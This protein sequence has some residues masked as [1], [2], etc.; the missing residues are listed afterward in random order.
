MTRKEQILLGYYRGFA[1]VQDLKA[2]LNDLRTPMEHIPFISTAIVEKKAIEKAK[3]ANQWTVGK[4]R[5]LREMWENG[6]RLREIA[7]AIG[8]SESAVQG[9]AKRL[10]LGRRLKTRVLWTEENDQILA[11]MWLEG[12]KARKISEHFGGI[13]RDAIYHRVSRLGLAGQRGAGV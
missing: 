8:T 4:V 3:T 1:T 7:D 12:R 11:Q 2:V 6:D 13:S 10:G 9:K 5:R